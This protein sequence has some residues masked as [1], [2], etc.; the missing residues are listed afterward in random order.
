MTDGPKVGDPEFPIGF[1]N[2]VYP[3]EKAKENPV[4][5]EKDY[6]LAREKAEQVN[7]ITDSNI[8]RMGSP[9]M[10]LAEAPPVQPQPTPSEA[11]DE[12]LRRLKAK[13][14]EIERLKIA[15]RAVLG[16]GDE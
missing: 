11:I 4:Q 9:P 6:W 1:A 15:L 14:A 7:N 2:M 12:L 16:G 13:D 3:T 8:Q 10:L 5:P